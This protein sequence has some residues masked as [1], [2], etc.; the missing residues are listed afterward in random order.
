ML[1]KESLFSAVCQFIKLC[2][3]KGALIDLSSLAYWGFI[4]LFHVIGECHAKLRSAKLS[5][6]FHG[7]NARFLRVHFV[8]FF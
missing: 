1:A 3:T 8:H 5:A 2:Q 6:D 4:R 7:R